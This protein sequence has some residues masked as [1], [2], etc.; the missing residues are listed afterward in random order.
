MRVPQVVDVR[1]AVAS[2]C[3][4]A[5][6]Y[7]QRRGV[8]SAALVLDVYASRCGGCALQ[9]LPVDG[10]R[11]GQALLRQRAAVTAVHEINAESNCRQ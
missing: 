8:E 11:G 3:R 7:E 2:A 10:K 5:A 6:A 9:L 4:A 1:P